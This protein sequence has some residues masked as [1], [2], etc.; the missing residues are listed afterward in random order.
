M[1]LCSHS[2]LLRG[3]ADVE[4]LKLQLGIGAY[5][6]VIQDIEAV[7]KNG[8]IAAEMLSLKAEAYCRSGKLSEGIDLFGKLDSASELPDFQLLLYGNALRSTGKFDA[9][10]EIYRKAELAGNASALHYLNTLETAKSILSQKP[11]FTLIGSP[12]NSEA[13]DFGISFRNDLAVITTCRNTLAQDLI[14]LPAAGQ[15]TL[16]SN[17]EKYQLL[18][19]KIQ[20][21]S[22]IGP[23]SFISDINEFI[24][25]SAEMSED[26]GPVCDK[27][28][29]TLFLAS[30]NASGMINETAT[31]LF[32][33]FNGSV[34][35]AQLTESGYT[36]YFSSNKAGGS[37]GYDIYV[38]YK[39]NGVWSIPQNLGPEINTPGNEIT[40]FFHAGNIY[41]A[42]DYLP[43]IGGYDI[44]SSVLENGKWSAP[45]NMGNII[46]S[47]ANESFPYK[48]QQN[49]FYITSDRLGGKGHNDIYQVIRIMDQDASLV[50]SDVLND[51]PTAV[52]WQDENK[53][54]EPA[55]SLEV[56]L[57]AASE[58]IS[59]RESFSMPEYVTADHETPTI[60]ELTAAAP[61]LSDYRNKGT[62][63]GPNDPVYFIQVV[64][65][66]SFQPDFSHFHK[67]TK[68]GNLYK[69]TYNGVVK[70]RLGYFQTRAEADELVTIVRNMGY[71]DAFI[72][73]EN[74]NISGLE[75]IM[76]KSGD[77]DKTTEVVAAP[78]KDTKNIANIYKVRLAA[79][80]DPIWFDINKVKDLGRIEQ[81][82]KGTWTI[83]I[84]AGFENFD[85]ARKAQQAAISRGFRTAEV[86]VDN[87][88]ILER[89]QKD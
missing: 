1:L 12:F 63:L 2:I 10:A 5:Q 77:D 23:C 16:L 6:R 24:F 37:G 3:Q 62:V 52:L 25:I 14:S 86:V 41:F 75:L 36:I 28:K 72:I 71:K 44:F 78:K 85:E 17:G 33:D 31:M 70:V 57:V 65:L 76:V 27:N 32:E 20:N 54:T 67:L 15:K 47:L 18:T 80:E 59:E 87:L 21:G 35:S 73:H 29:G 8:T 38:T 40:P 68:Y 64:S 84:L 49:E 46:N 9:A 22:F 61:A 82:T 45:E 83:F 34:H 66:T 50:S 4:Q 48:N 30:L 79:Y 51:A 74:M 89:I 39:I 26:C 81:W 43:G 11:Q 60:A 56:K 58:I 19:S 55:S 69:V 42:S 7:E 53:A 88:G 13:S